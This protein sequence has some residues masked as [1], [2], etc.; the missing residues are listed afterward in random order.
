MLY[1]AIFDMTL[2]LDKFYTHVP[3]HNKPHHRGVE[4]AI[5]LMWE[6]DPYNRYAAAW[7]DV[8]HTW[9]PRQWD[10]KISATATGIVLM[11]AWIVDTK[12]EF[13]INHRIAWTIFA[14]RWKLDDRQA[15]LADADL[16]A[17]GSPFPVY[18]ANAA[19]LFIEQCFSEGNYAPSFEQIMEFW[20]IG[21]EKFFQ[22][23]T[24]ITGKEDSIYLTHMAEKA[25][26]HFPTNR[27]SVRTLA[28]HNPDLLVAIIQK[29]WVKFFSK[30][31]IVR[32]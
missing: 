12:E 11:V 32:K 24:Q 3:Y 16:Y 29:E 4:R 31:L 2:N 21:Q 28:Q 15:P 27:D 20:T 14:N 13:E 1:I 10:E 7:H 30:P 19:R 8:L 17:I 6:W 18:I 22:H 25:F 9:T 26:P 5:I 23:L